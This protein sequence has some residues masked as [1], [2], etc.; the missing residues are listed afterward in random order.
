MEADRSQDLQS[1]SWRPRRADSVVLVRPNAWEPGWRVVL[2][3]RPA[4]SR[5]RKSQCF[6][7]CLKTGEKLTW[8]LE[9]SQ[10]GGIPS[11]SQRGQ[12]FGSSQGFS[13]LDEGGQSALLSLSIQM[14]TSSRNLHTDAPGIMFDHISGHPCVKLT[15]KINHQNC[16]VLLIFQCL[17]T[18]ASNVS[19]FSLLLLFKMRK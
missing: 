18:F 12:P 16:P 1:A 13:W 2:V 3:W 10:Q 6:S 19:S 11:H 14:L 9:G 7:L 17:K 5:S 15:H 4:D 8:W